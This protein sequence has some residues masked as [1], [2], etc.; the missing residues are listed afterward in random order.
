MY[1][2]HT[3]ANLAEE[4]EGRQMAVHHARVMG[5][6][7]A[8]ANFHRNQIRAIK[9]ELARRW[10]ATA[11]QRNAA[12]RPARAARVIQRAFRQMY[13]KPSNN[14]ALRGT[15]HSR[16]Y[17]K[18]M[19]RARGVANTE[20]LNRIALKIERLKINARRNEAQ[21]KLTEARNLTN[22]LRAE[23]GENATTNALRRARARL[24]PKRGRS[25]SPN[26]N[27]KAARRN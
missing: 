4:L 10:R 25:A 23:Y 24:N 19:A 15:L 17:R 14:N 16:G 3:N 9:S 27:R 21:G 20:N 5:L 2:H 18:A 6:P 13:Y 7:A 22:N 11:V 8:Y 12:R 1:R 26:L